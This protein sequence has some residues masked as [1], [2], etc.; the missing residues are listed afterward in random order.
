M[1]DI[2]PTAL[3]EREQKELSN[4]GTMGDRLAAFTA[5]W[6]RKEATL[7][8]SGHGIAIPLNEID[9]IDDIVTFESSIDD[10]TGSA[11]LTSIEVPQGSIGAIATTNPV[12]AITRRFI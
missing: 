4:R 5:F 3:N 12:S 1:T 8:M 2:I 7:K 11:H 10:W 6:C 9:V